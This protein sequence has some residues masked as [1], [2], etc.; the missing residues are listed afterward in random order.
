MQAVFADCRKVLLAAKAMNNTHTLFIF[1][2]TFR[3]VIQETQANTLKNLINK[4]GGAFGAGVNYSYP[5]H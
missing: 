2:K 3:F 5:P 4:P 1:T